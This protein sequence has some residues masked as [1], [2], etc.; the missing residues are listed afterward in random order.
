[1]TTIRRWSMQIRQLFRS[2]RNLNGD[3]EDKERAELRQAMQQLKEAVNDVVHA[4]KKD[5]A[6]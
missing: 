5:S 6:A 4:A 3:S 2:V 1:M